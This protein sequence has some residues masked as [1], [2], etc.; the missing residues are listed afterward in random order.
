[1]GLIEPDR[2]VLDCYWLAYWYK[3]SP[4]HFLAMTLSEL[5]RHIHFTNKISEKMTPSDGE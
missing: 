5:A 2:F 1:M 4:N 3:Q